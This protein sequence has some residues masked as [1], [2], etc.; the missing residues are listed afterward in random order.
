MTCKRCGGE[1]PDNAQDG[2]CSSYCRRLGREM[3]RVDLDAEF[4]E[5]TRDAL[6]CVDDDVAAME[7]IP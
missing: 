7:V 4:D 1:L 2:Y 6:R 3:G 5:E